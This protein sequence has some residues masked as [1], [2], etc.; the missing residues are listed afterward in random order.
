MARSGAIA[1]LLSY[2]V[3]R[4]CQ[5]NLGYRRQWDVVIPPTQQ[6]LWLVGTDLMLD[7]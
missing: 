6:L 2:K 3:I 5:R 4:R 1:M 7:P